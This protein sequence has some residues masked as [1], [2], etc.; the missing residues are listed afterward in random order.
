MIRFT[1]IKDFTALGST[2]PV[3]ALDAFN[4]D[5]PTLTA[6]SPPAVTL[7]SYV[8]HTLVAGAL[9]LD[10]TALVNSEGTTIDTTG[11]KLQTIVIENPAGN[12]DMTVGIGASNGYALFGTAG[13]VEVP[14][15]A[16]QDGRMGQVFNDQTPDVAG[17]AKEIDI[18]G[19]GTE[20]VRIGMT[21]G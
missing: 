9:T 21:F 8:E 4:G 10:L 15:S 18:T 20:K 7:E 5:G 2:S 14:A 17:G 13:K 16:T 3:V 12:A 6:S 1:C 11:L 19:T